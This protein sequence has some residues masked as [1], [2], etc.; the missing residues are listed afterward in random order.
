M[1][2]LAQFGVKFNKSLYIEYVIIVTYDNRNNLKNTVFCV[3][4]LQFIQ[5]IVALLMV[6]L[7]KYSFSALYSG[8][9]GLL[10]AVIPTIAYAKVVIT[11]KI[12]NANIMYRKHKKAMMIKFIING[13]IFMLVFLFVKN[14]NIFSLFFVYIVA[15]SGYWTSLLSSIKNK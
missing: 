12:D 10:I 2:L 6:F 7:Y 4:K 11:E 15:I 5:G 13:M 1:V 9:L 3:I 14:I 8:F